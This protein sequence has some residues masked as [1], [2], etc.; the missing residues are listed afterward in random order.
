[1]LFVAYT[2]YSLTYTTH[3]HF[4]IVTRQCG[5]VLCKPCSDKFQLGTGHCYQCEEKCKDRDLLGLRNEGTGYAGAKEGSV[6]VQRY[7]LSML[8]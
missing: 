2:L 8:V 5:H 6:E 1:M 3:S 4:Q 7:D